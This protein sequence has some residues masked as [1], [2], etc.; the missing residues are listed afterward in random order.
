MGFAGRRTGP[1]ITDFS[2]VIAALPR[3]VSRLLV[4]R[5]IILGAPPLV[6]TLPRLRCGEGLIVWYM[7]CRTTPPAVETLR[8][9]KP[10]VH[11]FPYCEHTC[12]AQNRRMSVWP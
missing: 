9:E 4:L 8:E 5:E 6:Q 2:K 12:Y 10:N 1:A 11:R 7:P 3:T